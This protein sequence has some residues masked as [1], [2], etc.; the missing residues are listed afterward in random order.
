[1]LYQ[2]TIKK[3]DDLNGCLHFSDNASLSTQ[4]PLTDHPGY[5]PEQLIGAA[6]ATCLQATIQ[7][8]L[9]EK[10][11]SLQSKTT[12]TVSLCPEKEN[13][14]YYFDVLAQ[15]SIEHLPL[16]EVESI[17]HAAHKRCPVSK[18]LQG[19]KTLRLEVVPFDTTTPPKT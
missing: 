2:T 5:N 14:G 12:I 15:A 8:I 9:E 10:G 11:Y 4:H 16:S 18:L 7:T 19:S 17:I 13:K 6:W 3:N 1:M